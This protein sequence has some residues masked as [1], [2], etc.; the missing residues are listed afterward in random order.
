MQPEPIITGSPT[1][2]NLAAEGWVA[3]TR[4]TFLSSLTTVWRREVDGLPCV[5]IFCEPAHDNGSGKMHGGILMTLAD[6]G[7]GAVVGHMRNKDRRPED[8][9]IYSPTA[10]LDMHFIDAVEIGDFVYSRAEPLRLTKSL[11]FVRG[12]L[13]VGEKIVASSQGVFKA[14][15]PG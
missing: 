5:G 11:T 10:Q 13:Q 12:T 9:R 14:L 6:V 8:G 2:F 4:R 7:L 1:A 15:R 3:D